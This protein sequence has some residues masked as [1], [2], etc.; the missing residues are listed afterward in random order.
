MKN[1]DL[2]ELTS[3]LDH[4]YL[5]C[6]QHECKPN[7]IIIDGYRKCSNH[8][9]LLEQLKTYQ[10]GKH[11]THRRSR[12]PAAWKDM[13]RNALRDIANWRTK[14]QS[15]YTKSQVFAWKNLNQLENCQKYAYKLSWHACTWHELVDLTLFGQ[16]TTLHVRLRNR[17]KPVTNDYLV[18]SPTFTTQVTTDNVVMW[19]TRLSIIDWICSK[20]LCLCWRPWGLK[21]NLGSESY[22]LSEVEHSSPLVG[23]ARNKRQ[24]PTVLQNLKL[25]RWMLVQ[26]WTGY[27]LSICGTCVHRRVPSRQPTRQQ[28]TA[29]ELT[30]PRPEQKGESRCWSLVARGLRH[31]ERKFLSRRVPVVHRWRQR[32]SDPNDHHQRQKSNDETRVKNPQSCAW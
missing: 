11:L 2:D 31:H 3:F 28:E 18:W 24:Y 6:T 23:C 20:T 14:K 13:L 29:R 1:V 32:S 22:V 9:F 16:W 26:G 12:G 25:F 4:V 7:E 8:E 30:N 21:I 19:E 17:P 27:M 5:G 15:S 10:G